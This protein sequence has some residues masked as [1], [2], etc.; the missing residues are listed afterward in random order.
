M[1]NDPRIRQLLIENLMKSGSNEEMLQQFVR[2]YPYKFFFV[3]FFFIIY[4]FVYYKN[5]TCH[6]ERLER[7]MNDDSSLDGGR[8]DTGAMGDLDP[9]VNSF[10]FQK[11]SNFYYICISAMMLLA[12]TLVMRI[13]NDDIFLSIYIYIY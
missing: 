8:F 7:E 10:Y 6:F 3:G 12:K 5:R 11:K 2:N 9:M 4:L 1:N 13:S